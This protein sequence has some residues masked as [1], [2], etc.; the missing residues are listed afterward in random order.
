M[1]PKSCSRNLPSSTA[2]Y[3]AAWC[4]DRIY[5]LLKSNHY[6]ACW[7]H[8]HL[9]QALL[10]RA[11]EIRARRVELQAIDRCPAYADFFADWGTIPTTKD[12]YINKYS[13]EDRCYDGQIPLG[14]IVDESSGS[15]GIP[16]NWVRSRQEQADLRHSIQ[17]AYQLTHGDRYRSERTILLNCFA[18]GSWATGMNISTALADVGILKSIGCDR[19]KLENTLRQFGTDY[20]YL[21]FGYPPFIK[22]FIDLSPLDLSQYK[23]NL[24]VGGEPISEGLRSYLLQYFETVVSSYGA[25]DLEINLG[26]ETDL[27]IALRRLCQ[28]DPTLSQ[29]LFNRSTPPSIFQYNPIEHLIETSPTGELIYT[30]TRS[31]GAAPKVRYNL[32][33]CGGTMTYIE[34]ANKLQLAGINIDLLAAKRSHLPILFVC[35]RSDLTVS[36]YGAN[37]YPAEIAEIIQGHEDFHQLIHSFQLACHENSQIDARLQI[38]LELM[39]NVSTDRLSIELLRDWFLQQLADRNQDFREVTKMFDRKSIAIELQTYGAG[40]FSDRDPQIKHAYIAKK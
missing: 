6:S 9:L 34:L 32:L 37:I 12:N 26:R 14:A 10:V 28:L 35:G 5:N 19:Q 39:P 25:S 20:R 3:L 11:G 29:E 13:I 27:T 24:I 17:Q 38:T 33:D 30:V 31:N 23:L 18:L 22:S 40:V 1:F 7:L 36:F 16:S 2:I 21:I 8:F 15:S 4:L